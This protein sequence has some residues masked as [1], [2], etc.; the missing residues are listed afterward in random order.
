MAIKK[1]PVGRPKGIPRAENAGRQKG[2]AEKIERFL[3]H[4]V[5]P[6]ESRKLNYILDTYKRKYNLRKNE[7]IKKIFFDIAEHENIEFKEI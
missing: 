6:A 7:A 4:R 2:T 1:R 5:T 3:T